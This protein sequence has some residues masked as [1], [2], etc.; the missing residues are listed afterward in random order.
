MKSS[1]A[2]RSILIDGHK[3]SVSL[4]DPFWTE[5]KKIAHSQR[6]T[7][8][9]LVTAIDHAREHGNL[10]S[11][12]RLFVLH[13]FRNDDTRREAAKAHLFAVGAERTRAR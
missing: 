13:H 10:S 4:E 12:I 1:V 5:L 11:A 2:K 9:E 6:V 8:S 7:L 3:T